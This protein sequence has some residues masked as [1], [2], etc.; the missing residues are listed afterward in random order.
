MKM[1]NKKSK[2][3]GSIVGRDVIGRRR[4]EAHQS[5]MISYF[6]LPGVPWV[7]PE[8]Y[9]RRRF[10]MGTDL[11]I[12]S[13]NVIRNFEQRRGYTGMLGHSTLQKMTAA[14]HILAYGIPADLV[15]DNIAMA[16]NITMD[17]N[18]TKVTI[19]LTKYTH[20]GQRLPSH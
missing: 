19:L 6:R 12:Y 5:L 10:L 7:Y 2:H 16:E 18:T 9:F 13:S 4:Q 8:K 17:T 1:M 14:L 11:F 20:N 3:G 15:D